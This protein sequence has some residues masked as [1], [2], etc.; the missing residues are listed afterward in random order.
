M[1]SVANLC[2]G[3]FALRH[4]AVLV[5]LASPEQKLPRVIIQLFLGTNVSHDG[6]VTETKLRLAVDGLMTASELHLGPCTKNM[7]MFAI[8]IAVCCSLFFWFLIFLQS[9]QNQ[10]ARPRR[11]SPYRCAAGRLHYNL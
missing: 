6:L 10:P 1:L 7:V 2:F 8:T 4:V 5:F 11:F 3:A 9:H